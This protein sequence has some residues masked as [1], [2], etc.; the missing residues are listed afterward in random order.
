MTFSAPTR[1]GVAVETVTVRPAVCGDGITDVPFQEVVTR[2][3]KLLTAAGFRI[4][5]AEG[6]GPASEVY[7]DY[8]LSPEGHV[9]VMRDVSCGAVE[10]SVAIEYVGRE[11]ASFLR[12]RLAE[13]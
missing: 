1:K 10:V 4:V 6:T 3:G 5:D 11:V 13:P 8:V 2:I 9:R 12:T 7:E